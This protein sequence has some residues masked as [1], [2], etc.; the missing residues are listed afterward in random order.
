MDRD[1]LSKVLRLQKQ[2]YEALLWINHN[3]AAR[4]A[5]FAHGEADLL[6]HEQTCETWLARHVNCLPANLRPD[7]KD[8]AAFA[9]L[10]S[11]FFS[12]SFELSAGGWIVRRHPE[13]RNKRARAKDNLAMQ[14]LQRFALQDLAESLNLVH[15][16]ERA[17]A[18]AEDSTTV[19]DRLLWSYAWELVRRSQFA[20]Q[21][22]AVHQMWRHLDPQVRQN[23]DVETLWAARGRLAALLQERSSM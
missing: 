1:V 5:C 12:T 16:V 22:R 18:V 10:L 20:S 13:P 6:M 23:L 14:H 2:A 3:Q 8:A 21:G 15:P 19:E 7:P 11:S 17:A 9:R 4:D